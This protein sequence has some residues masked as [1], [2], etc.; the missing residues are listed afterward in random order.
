MIFGDLNVL[1]WVV[2]KSDKNIIDDLNESL[3]KLCSIQNNT[4]WERLVNTDEQR[5]TL[6]PSDFKGI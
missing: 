1:E 3:A 6:F 4:Y 2:L 5:E